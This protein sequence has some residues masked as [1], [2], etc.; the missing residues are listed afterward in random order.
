MPLVSNMELRGRKIG[1]EIGALENARNYVNIV[2]KT[3][4]GDLPLEIQQAVD[5]ISVLSILDELLKLA[6]T[7][8]SFEEFQQFLEQCSQ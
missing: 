3:R 2:L 5:E 7:V 8:N 4:L 1:K 6:L